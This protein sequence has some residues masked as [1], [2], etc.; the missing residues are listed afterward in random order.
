MWTGSDPTPA[1]ALRF[2]VGCGEKDD[3]LTRRILTTS[4]TIPDPLPAPLGYRYSAAVVWFY[5]ALDIVP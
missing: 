1:D 2:L 3:N 5:Y 4:P